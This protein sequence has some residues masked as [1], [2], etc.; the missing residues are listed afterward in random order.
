MRSPQLQFRLL[1]PIVPTMATAATTGCTL[2]F[3]SGFVNVQRSAVEFAAVQFRNGAIR[4]R[5]HAHFDKSKSSGLAGIPVGYDVNAVDGTIRLEQ[6]SNCGFGSSEVEVS[7]KNILHF[8]F[9][10]LSGLVNFR[11]GSDEADRPD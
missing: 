4:I 2:S 7:Y 5:V 9:P 1:P 8:F 11:A 10:S 3:R 6:R